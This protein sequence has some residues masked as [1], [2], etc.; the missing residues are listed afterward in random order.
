MISVIVPVHNQEKTIQAQIER[1]YSLGVA[2]EII[3]V[4]DGSQDNTA[5]VLR[6]LSCGGLKVIHH[7]S[8]RGPSAAVR[9]A[10]EHTSGDFIF[11]PNGNLEENPDNYL[12]LLAAING[13]GADIVLGARSTPP[14]QGSRL[15][16]A[17]NYFLAKILNIVWGVRLD[18][19]FS[20][21]QLIRRA[22]LLDLSPQLKGSNIA[23]EIIIRGLRKK[24]RVAEVF[25]TDD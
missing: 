15:Q 11:I 16:Q 21:F 14:H 10:L 5:A 2:K 24:M 3:V 25:I 4:N 8:N 12:K 19:W 7:V 6:G 23:F 1:L 18:G 13:S 20:H 17:K 9:T 22:S